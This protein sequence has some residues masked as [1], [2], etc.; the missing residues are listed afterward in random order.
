M[1]GSSFGLV[2]SMSGLSFGLV[3]YKWFEFRIGHSNK[4]FEF[5]IGQL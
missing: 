4:W 1:S 3:I 2:I 5:P